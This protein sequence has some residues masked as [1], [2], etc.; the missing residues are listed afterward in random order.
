MDYFE[1]YY[2]LFGIPHF[3][4]TSEEIRAAYIKQVRYFH[5]DAANVPPDI[6]RDRTQQLNQAYEILR[7][8]EKKRIYDENLFSYLQEKDAMRRRQEEQERQEKESMRQETE[9][10]QIKQAQQN[11]NKFKK[12]SR[13]Y[14]CFTAL[15]LVA[16]CFIASFYV[17]E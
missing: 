7:E 8:P 3:Y 1:D 17:N 15:L 10:F 12:R 2:A 16:C 13:V 14:M 11:A 9:N 5:P 4:A 6:A